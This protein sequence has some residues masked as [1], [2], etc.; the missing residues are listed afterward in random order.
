MP[1]PGVLRDRDRETSV[2]TMELFVDLV[3]V[4]AVTQM[5]HHL[6]NGDLHGEVSGDR[7]TWTSAGQTLVLLGLVWGLWVYTTWVTNWLNPDSDAVRFLLIA[8]MLGSLAMSCALPQ[9]FGRWGG[10]VGILYAVM[11]IGRSVVTAVLLRGNELQS[12]FVRISV[13]CTATGALAV[14]G[15]FSDPRA[16]VWLW[17]AVVILDFVGGVIGFAVPGLGRSRSD[18]DWATVR[19]SHFAERCQGFVL[20]ALGESLI[21]IG[22]SMAGEF[23]QSYVDG[24][25]VASFVGA[26]V[27][28]VALWW[29]YFDRSGSQGARLVAASD[30]PGA[31]I[32]WAYHRIHPVMIA[33]IIVTAAADELIFRAPG[34]TADAAVLWTTLGGIALYIAGH[35]AFKFVVWRRVP[36]AHLLAVVVLASAGVVGGQLSALS[37]GV[38]GAMVLIG[39]CVADRSIDR[40]SVRP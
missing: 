33:G 36:V 37:V 12:N 39:L 10:V 26:F 24:Q 35:A 14:V 29:L 5:S 20:I 7:P 23:G 38:V 19:G 30:D 32:G 17:S 4:F 15:G 11:Q 9:A 8:L 27:G 22:A 31:L 3:F 40:R 28:A 16:R 2:T 25:R 1:Q 18:Q 6:L 34:R 21:V 13:W